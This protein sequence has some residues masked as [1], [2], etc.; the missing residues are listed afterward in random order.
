M[1]NGKKL[2]FVQS[3]EMLCMNATGYEYGSSL[4]VRVARAALV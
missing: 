2:E 1:D 3:N 4:G